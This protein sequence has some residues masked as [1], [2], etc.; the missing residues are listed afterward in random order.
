M[1][2]SS[3]MMPSAS[4]LWDSVKPLSSSCISWGLDTARVCTCCARTSGLSSVSPSRALASSTSSSSEPALGWGREPARKAASASVT[5]WRSSARAATL[6]LLISARTLWRRASELPAA[7][8]RA[9]TLDLILPGKAAA[10]SF[11]AVSKTD[12]Q[13]VIPSGDITGTTASGSRVGRAGVLGVFRRIPLR[14]V[15][16]TTRSWDALAPT[17]VL[18]SGLGL[19]L[20]ITESV[21]IWVAGTKGKAAARRASRELDLG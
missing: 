14:A 7:L 15:G 11:Q 6:S 9:N 21:S 5:L 17:A 12:W 10:Y 4:S 8:R 19:K 1:V 20:L 18:G 3:S 16:T 13:P 2:T